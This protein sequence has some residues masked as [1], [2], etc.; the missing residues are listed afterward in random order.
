MRNQS[1]DGQQRTREA[2]HMY[3]IVGV[4][5]GPANLALAAAVQDESERCGGQNLSTL[6]LERQMEFKWHPGMLLEGTRVQVPFLKDLVTLQNPR[7]R[8][9]FLNYLQMQGR[10]HDFV[11]MRE[12]YPSRIEFNDY[13]A[14][15]AGQLCHRVRYGREILAVSPV[16][17]S[18]GERIEVLKIVG[19]DTVSG[20]LEEYVTRN[21]VIASGRKP[22]IPNRINIHLL[23]RAFH[24]QDFLHQMTRNYGYKDRPYRF[25]V[26]GSGQSA[27]EIF[28]HLITN[29]IKADVTATIR[30]FAYRPIDDSHFVN[31]MFLP[32]TV[33]FL[34]GLPEDKRVAISKSHY[35]ATYSVV[36]ADLIKKIYRALYNEKM[37]GR[38]RARIRPFLELRGLVGQEAKVV[39][40]FYDSLHER[41]LCIEG[42]AIIFATGYIRETHLPFLD[43]LN[44]YLLKN[45]KGEY[46]VER[47]YRI[48][49]KPSFEPNVFLQGF[50]EETHGI[51]D[52]ALSIL[53]I[54]AHEI[55]QTLKRRSTPRS[56][57][58]ADAH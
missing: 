12:F 7:S 54:R 38:D 44:P 42:D 27:A 11:N 28:Y 16:S 35:N 49:G 8:F 52:A 21:L 18:K 1:L 25:I 3:D 46:K 37:A 9:S 36:E 23:Q 22:F 43:E 51:S 30:Q 32:C 20:K 17:Y 2:K 48:A 47:D 26:V 19:R 4:G 34:Y 45:E 39:G 55:L 50:C 58:L 5:L 33:D 10:L 29:Y 13:Y 57:T 6:F 40:Q 56:A 15:V 14:W 53:P 31:E 41:M 24:A